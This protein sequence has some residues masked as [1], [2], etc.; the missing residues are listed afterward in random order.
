[1][2]D[3]RIYAFVDGQLTRLTEDDSLLASL[4]GSIDPAQHA[5]HPLRNVLTNVLGAREETEVHVARPSAARPGMRLLLCSDGLHGVVDDDRIAAE[6]ADA[7]TPRVA[8]E[9]LVAAALDA[10]GRDNVTALVVDA[11]RRDD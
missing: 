3:S 4:Q 9:R 6:L 10:K 2:G 8:S 1:M 7:A 5:K 11:T